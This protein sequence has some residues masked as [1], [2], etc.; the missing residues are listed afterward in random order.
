[1]SD[2]ILV[3]TTT[4]ATTNVSASYF[5]LC[6][7][8]AVASENNATRFMVWSNASGNVKVG[9]YADNAG[10]PGARMGYN[11]T[12]QAVVAGWNILTVSAC[13]IV[14]GTY[15][16]LGGDIGTA[17]CFRRNATGTYRYKSSTFSTFVFPDPAGTGFSTA[18]YILSMAVWGSVG[19]THIAKINGLSAANIAKVNGVSAASISKIFGINV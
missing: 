12:Q 7:Y 15:Y 4:E 6:Q 3:G 5:V 9:V 10:E 2:V 19:W 13:D 14:S 1:M 18:S 16:W 11:D 17:G 8:Q